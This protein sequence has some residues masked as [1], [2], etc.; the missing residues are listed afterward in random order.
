[1]IRSAFCFVTASIVAFGQSAETAQ[2]LLKT[3]CQGCH[4]DQSKTAS[5]SLDAVRTADVATHAEALEK[6][7]RK[8]RTGEMPPPGLPRPKAAASTALARW[9]EVELD[10]NIAK[11][12]NPGAPAAHRLNRAEYA[13][14]IRDL[15]ALDL[16]HSAS[17]PADDSGYGFDNIGSVLTMSPLLLEKYMTTARRVSRQALGT[18]KLSP[19]VEKF[20]AARSGTSDT[21]DEL[22]LATR[23][24]LTLKHYFPA[25]AEYLF[26]VRVRGNPDPTLPPAKLDVRVDGVRT[27]LFD[28]VY[29]NAEE[30]QNSRNFEV[31]VPLKAGVHTIGASFLAET[32]ERLK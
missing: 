28:A 1:M 15:L 7:L 5:F 20:T 3:Y 30:S 2:T 4:N 17:L 10:Q 14:A 12:P 27:K 19:L 23:N 18:T 6:V 16:E 24:G 26:T 31:R 21:G 9:L 22:P 32:I 11:H 8:I 29:N 13:N 25:D